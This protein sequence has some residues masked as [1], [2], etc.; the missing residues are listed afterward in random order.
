M[1]CEQFSRLA[2]CADAGR[3]S[4]FA[5]VNLEIHSLW[6]V[7]ICPAA[8]ELSLARFVAAWATVESRRRQNEI[9]RSKKK[10]GLKFF[11][12]S[13]MTNFSIIE[14]AFL[15]SSPTRL[16]DQSLSRSIV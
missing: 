12:G 5:A 10:S 4:K 9:R 7:S 8:C 3:F 13:V 14:E 11:A 1:E 2:G 15:F 16:Y 6:V